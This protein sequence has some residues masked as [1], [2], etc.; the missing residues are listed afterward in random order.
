MAAAAKKLGQLC[1]TIKEAIEET[2][3][4][5]PEEKLGGTSTTAARSKPSLCASSVRTTLPTKKT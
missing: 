1:D 2:V 5:A 4:Q 3:N